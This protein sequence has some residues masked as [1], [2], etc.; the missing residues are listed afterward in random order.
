MRDY[1]IPA[2]WHLLSIKPDPRVLFGVDWP[3][4]QDLG[5][6]NMHWHL[7]RQHLIHSKYRFRPW[8][9]A[10]A[11]GITWQQYC[12]Q[13]ESMAGNPDRNAGVVYPASIQN[14]DQPKKRV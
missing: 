2:W 8:Y 11:R 1:K 13:R 6:T 10:Y 14:P 7:V 5:C 3:E 9:P 12:R 4:C